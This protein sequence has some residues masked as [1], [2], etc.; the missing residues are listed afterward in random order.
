[1]RIQN[2]HIDEEL[3][4]SEALCYTCEVMDGSKVFG[5]SYFSARHVPEAE[6]ESQIRRLTRALLRRLPRIIMELENDISMLAREYGYP[7]PTEWTMDDFSDPDSRVYFSSD[8]TTRL[9]LV[10]SKIGCLDLIID[11]DADFNVTDEPYLD[12]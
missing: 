11:L 2:I 1:M 9:S 7:E 12:G 8:H 4:D 6:L 10:V 5:V 3:S